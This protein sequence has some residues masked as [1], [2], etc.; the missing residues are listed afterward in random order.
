MQI[1]SSIF[2]IDKI[3]KGF[4]TCMRQYNLQLLE[5]KFITIKGSFAAVGYSS[6]KST[7]AHV[8]IA[9]DTVDGVQVMNDHIWLNNSYLDNY[10]LW[11]SINKGSEVEIYGLVYSY[12]TA[13]KEKKYSIYPYSIS[14]WNLNNVEMN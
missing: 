13:N 3:N 2:D 4:E 8:L 6:N 10:N 14:T 9:Y 1:K 5:N 12:I 7:L 11:N